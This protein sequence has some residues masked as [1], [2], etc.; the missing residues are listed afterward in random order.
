MWDCFVWKL[1]LG[2][3]D[4]YLPTLRI[5]SVALTD[6]LIADAGGMM[7]VCFVVKCMM[8]TFGS[9][10]CAMFCLWSFLWEISL[11]RRWSFL[12]PGEWLGFKCLAFAEYWVGFLVGKIHS[13]GTSL[14][15][16][17]LPTWFLLVGAGFLC[18]LVPACWLLCWIL[19]QLGKY[20]CVLL[21]KTC[22]QLCLCHFVW[23]YVYK[24]LCCRKLTA[25]LVNDLTVFL[26]ILGYIFVA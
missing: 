21:W 22:W 18:C 19:M 24:G 20:Q 10:L 17:L 26:L 1:S 11:G 23:Y 16:L 2:L 4:G 3:W 15:R 9:H 14:V 7:P 8:M 12:L 6:V 5:V 13:H 25:L